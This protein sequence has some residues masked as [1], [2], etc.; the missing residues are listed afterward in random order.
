MY[1]KYRIKDIS[2]YKTFVLILSIL[3]AGCASLKEMANSEDESENVDVLILSTSTINPDIFNRPSPVRLDFFQ[4]QKIESFAYTSYLDL[5]E[6]E[7]P[8]EK[9]KSRS[10]YIIHP[11][12]L[13]YINYEIKKDTKYLGV[14]AG[15]RNIDDVKWQLTLSKQPIGWNESGNNYLYLKLDQSGI[16]Q[17]SEKE[18]KIELKQY[19]KQHPEDKS[20]TKYG[21]FKK[22][23]YDYSK[24]IFNEKEIL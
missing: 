23:K 22:P 10:Q 6:E 15:Y 1:I 17:L 19:A 12:S 11:D 20:V 14:I 16:K 2:K 7:G 8:T 13:K 24:G 5:I 9:I 4:L 21:K 3:L 18:M